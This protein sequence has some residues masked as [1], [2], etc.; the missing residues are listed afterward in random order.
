MTKNRSKK[1]YIP[2][3][4]HNPEEL[5]RQLQQLRETINDYKN[6]LSA[7]IKENERHVIFSSNFLQHDMKNAIH[8]MDGIIS[9]TTAEQITEENIQSLKTSLDILRQTLD[10]F[11]N[12]IPH[13]QTGEFQ[14]V[15]LLSSVEALSRNNLNKNNVECFYDYDRHSTILI[16]Q[17]FQA[18]LQILHNLVINASKAMETMILKKMYIYATVDD[19]FCEIK[20][21]D[22]GIPIPKEDL[23]KIFLYG[24]SKTGGTGIGLFHAKYTC[25]SINGSIIVN[26][27]CEKPISKE[28]IIKFPIIKKR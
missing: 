16:N 2:Q 14:L 11:T 6:V 23:E 8:T 22:T 19:E 28:F 25:D 15:D 1:I 20:I 27:K 5:A 3:K 9:T 24:F 10:N 7:V 4:R 12:V 21:A 18:L 26:N 17:S 13:T